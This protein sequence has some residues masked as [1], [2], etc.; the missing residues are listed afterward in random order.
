MVFVCV[1]VCVRARACFGP[2]ELD[3]GHLKLSAIGLDG[4]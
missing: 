3:P 4:P 1:C 2:P